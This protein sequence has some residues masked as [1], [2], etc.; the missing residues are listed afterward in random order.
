MATIVHSRDGYVLHVVN[1]YTLNAPGNPTIIILP[2][3]RAKFACDFLEFRPEFRC[4]LCG[5][6]SGS[7]SNYYSNTELLESSRAESR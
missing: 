2:F 5:R 4:L 3:E 6:R 1:N 7:L